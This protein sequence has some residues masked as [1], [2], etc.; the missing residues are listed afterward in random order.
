MPLTDGAMQEFSLTLDKFLEHAAKWHP[1]TEVVTATDDG[2]V[3]RVGYADLL[4]RAKRV[5]SVLASLGVTKGHRAATLAWNTQ[6]HVEAWYGIMGMGAACH[7]LN[8]RLTGEQLAWMVDQSGAEILIASPD[9]APLV[10]QIERKVTGNLRQVLF[11]GGSGGEAAR[12]LSSL[13]DTAAA[14]LPWGE[15]DERDACGLCFTSG[16][17]GA[18]KGVT[19]THR[20][21]YLHTLRLLQADVL[22]ITS[23]DV[24]MPVVPMFHANA[25]GLPFACP[26]AGAKLVL[27][28]CHADG[29]SLAKL[30]AAEGVTI[31]AGVPTV[32]LAMFDYLDEAG[33]ELPSLRRVMVGG[34]PMPHALM[35][36]IEQRGIIVQTTWGMT[37][38]SPLG[39]ATPPG[40]TSRDHRM[41][42]RA[43]PGVDLRLADVEGVP[44]K[45][46]RGAEGHLWVRGGSVVERYL[47]ED[48]P[49]T[50]DGWFDTGDLAR[51]DAD[52]SLQI[53]GRSKDLIKSGGEWINPAEIEAIVSASPMV[54][55]AAVIGR[56]DPKWGERPLLL[57]EMRDECEA[58]DEELVAP[59]NGKVASWWIP[60]E[61]V[62]LKEMPLAATGKIDKLRLRDEYCRA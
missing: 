38:L 62:R 57:V 30:I 39:T 51:I 5:S 18:P 40:A 58:S 20:A 2:T 8:P 12:A 19:Y 14:D 31:V 15:F 37:E 1:E 45:E 44:L 16:T 55:Q 21:N 35:T 26:A 52:G 28:G 47:G 42:G 61:I 17:T 32:W 23:R 7:T 10:A 4:D 59:L 46:Q 50:V 56:A 48:E 41:S 25:W 49:A 29:A 11:T 6:E 36:R 60:Q 24:V 43:A 9:L 13:V 33:L 53:T 22:G 54:A 3:R 27:P 34:A